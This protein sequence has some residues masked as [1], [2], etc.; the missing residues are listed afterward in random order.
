MLLKSLTTISVLLVL[1]NVVS[2]QWPT[3]HLYTKSKPNNYVE[4]TATNLATSGFSNSKQTKILIHGFTDAGL[5]TNLL[6]VKD[7]ILKKEDANIIVVD[8]EKGAVAPNYF[9]AVVNA[10][11]TGLKVG[12]FISA[13]GINTA[14]IHCIGHSLG[15]HVI[16]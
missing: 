4:V 12:E 2:C 8:W 16:I 9:G 15:A 3:F 13:A 5:R 14:N 6:L 1:S 10:K 7:E 11:T